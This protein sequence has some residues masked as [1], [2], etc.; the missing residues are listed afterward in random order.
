MSSL[1]NVKASF[2]LNENQYNYEKDVVIIAGPTCVGKSVIA[3]KYTQG[4]V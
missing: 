3:M 1:L 2:D 4:R